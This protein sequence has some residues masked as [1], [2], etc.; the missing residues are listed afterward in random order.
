MQS[1]IR[2]QGLEKNARLITVG[3]TSI[4]DSRVQ[5]LGV[6]SSFGAHVCQWRNCWSNSLHREKIWKDS[7]N[8]QHRKIAL[9]NDFETFDMFEEVVHNFGESDDG[10]RGF[11][12]NLIKKSGKDSNFHVESAQQLIAA[13]RQQASRDRCMQGSS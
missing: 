2:P 10:I 3:P 12:S 13:A 9:K 6:L 11:M 5:G 7:T 1:L 8:F 4:P